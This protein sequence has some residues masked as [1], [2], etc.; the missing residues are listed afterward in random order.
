MRRGYVVVGLALLAGGVG[1]QGRNPEEERMSDPAPPPAAMI[2]PDRESMTLE[3]KLALLE[4]EL[5]A[6]LQGELEGRALTR[7]LRAEA[8]TDRLLE[9][10]PPFPWLATN[11]SVDTRL[12]QLQALA[13]RVVA[14]LR[15]DAP[16]ERV[17]RD[18]AALHKQVV[19]LQ[20]ELA[21]GGIDPPVPLDSLFAGVAVDS[22]S[23]GVGEGAQ[24]E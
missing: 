3:E 1:C 4:R 2:A 11:Y 23:M 19:E 24:G 15:R 20:E 17:L 8:I 14:Q 12:R 21:Q 13:D 9:S 6:A 10:A 7:M 16:R 18:V 22:L 5:S